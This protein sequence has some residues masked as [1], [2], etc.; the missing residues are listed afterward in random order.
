MLAFDTADAA[1]VRYRRTIPVHVRVSRPVVV[2]PVYP[3]VTP[4]TTTIVGPNVVIGPRGRLKYVTPV[5]TIAAPIY[6]R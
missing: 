5:R 3:V 6:L 4:V 2:A 1:H